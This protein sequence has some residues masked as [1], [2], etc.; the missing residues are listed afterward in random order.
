M[1]L[2]SLMFEAH[3]CSKSKGWWEQERNFP[4]QLALMHSEISE[5]LEEYRTWGMSSE[6][7]I[8]RTEHSP[9]PEGIAVE[10]ADAI[11]RICDNCQGFGIPLVEA[12]RQKMEYNRT[13]P[14]RHGGKIC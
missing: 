11:I 7:R 14:H 4:E 5:A 2:E 6:M 8:Y 10:L 9:K 3:D 13:R 1:D 12:I